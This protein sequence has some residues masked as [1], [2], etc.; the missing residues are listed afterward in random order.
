MKKEKRR[1]N[2]HEYMSSLVVVDAV[3]VAPLLT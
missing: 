1:C 3:F 2:Y